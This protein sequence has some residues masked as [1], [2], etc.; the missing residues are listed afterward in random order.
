MT[1]VSGIHTR[2]TH[3]AVPPEET[4]SRIAPLLSRYG[5]TRIAD[6]TGLDHIGIPVFQAV[7]PG[8]R[9][10]SVS[11]GKGLTRAAARVSAAMEA[12]ELRH[13]ENLIGDS[14]PAT[15]PVTAR[16]LGLPYRLDELDLADG[17]LVHPDLPLR[18]LT[19]EGALSGAAVPVPLDAVRLDHTF[20]AE[21]RPPLFHATSNGLA[22]GNTVPEATAHAL[23][24][25]CERDSLALLRRR[26]R[27]EWRRLE[28]PTVD[29]E[30]CRTL[31]KVY[32]EAGVQVDVVIATYPSVSPVCFEARIRSEALPVTFT[33]A[34]CHLDPAIALCRALT[35]AAQS[36]LTAIAGARDDLPA[37]LY[38]ASAGTAREDLGTPVPWNGRSASAA[39]LAADARVL[40][41]H[42]AER[43]GHEPVR[44]V[45]PSP[46]GIAVVKVVAPGL[47]FDSR[48]DVS[49]GRPA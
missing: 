28:L 49:A 6:V 25:L 19:G 9:T 15:G 20:R 44:V 22:S 39:D 2:G 40:A 4:W 12:V 32:A 1:T 5:V 34:G 29:D 41:H 21:W 18:W 38:R 3:R 31:L 46:T 36:R 14:G 24:E 26:P 13:A 17:S 47:A 42:I 48:T 10:V 16:A 11:Q 35:E 30:D 7:R 27:E 33:G 45:L 23:A 8:A 37:L 43:T